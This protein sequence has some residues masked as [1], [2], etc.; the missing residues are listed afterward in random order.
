VWSGGYTYTITLN[1]NLA[2]SANPGI[3]DMAGNAL[4]PNQSSGIVQYTITLVSGV[5]FSHAPGYPVAWHMLT[6]NPGL[7]LGTKAPLPQADYVPCLVRSPNTDDGVNFSGVSL[8][9]GESVTLPVTITVPAGLSAVYLYGWIDYSDAGTFTSSDE[10]F[11]NAT[12]GQPLANLQVGVNHLNL[13]IQ[14]PATAD[15]GTTWARFRV[16]TAAGLSFD[17]GAPDGEVE[18]YAVNILP[19]PAEIDGTVW[20][21]QNDN[22]AHDTGEPGLGGWTVTATD[23][24]GK[25][26]ATAITSS[27]AGALGTYS[28][29]GLAPGT[30][31]IREQAPAAG[32]QETAPSTGYLL[33][34]VASGQ[35]SP[36]NDFENF[37]P[38]NAEIDGLVWDDLTGSGGAYTNQPVL[39]GW[40]VYVDLNNSDAW[41]ANDPTAISQ[42]DGTFD[43][44]IPAAEQTSNNQY[45]VREVPQ[46]NWAETA[47]ASGFWNV[48]VAAGQDAAISA[49]FGDHYLL[50][51]MVN[52]LTLDASAQTPTNAKAV[53]FD[54]TFSEPVTGLVA[55]DFQVVPSIPGPSGAVVSTIGA[56]GSVQTYNGKS[57][58]S[59]WIVTINTGS[60]DGTLTFNLQDHGTIF[61]MSGNLLVAAD[62]TPNV[63]AGPTITIDKTP[64]T[65]A[66]TLDA[67]SHNPTNAASVTFDVTFSQAVTGVAANNGTTFTNLS[68]ASPGL[69]GAAI[70]KVSFSGAAQVVNGV[71]YYTTW[72][73]TV[74]SGLGNSGTLQ[75]SVNPPVTIA[76]PAGNDLI[77]GTSGPVVTIDRVQP[78][79]AISVASG[80]ANPA[81]AGPIL[82]TVT[83]SK[84]VTGFAAAGVSLAKSTAAGTLK[85]TVTP[86][87]SSGSAGYYTT[88]QVSVSGMT[89]GGTVVAGVLAGAATDAAGNASVVSTFATVTYNP[90]TAVTLALA[91]RNPTNGKSLTT[92]LAEPITFTA[93]FSQAVSNF[94][95]TA[96][97]AAS[98]LNFTGSTAGTGGTATGLTGTVTYSGFSGGTYNYSVVVSG[99][100]GTGNIVLAINKG[101]VLTASGGGNTASNSASVFYDITPPVAVMESPANG[102]SIGATTLNNQRYIEIAYSA[103]VGAGLSTA[104]ILNAKTAP[105]TLTGAAATGV[106]ITMPPTKASGTDTYLYAFTGSF[107]AGTV[108]VNLLANTV[109]DNAGNWNK[110]ASFSFTTMPGL[111]V[112]NLG[113]TKATSGTTTAVFTVSLSS[114]ATKAVSVR[115]ATANGTGATAGIA[116]TNYTAVSGTLSFAVG[117][118]SKTVSVPIIGNTVNKVAT[119]SLVL[120]A[121]TNAVITTSTGTGTINPPASVTKVTTTTTTTTTKVTSTSATTAVKAASAAPVTTTVVTPTTTTTT[122]SAAKAASLVVVATPSATATT[123]TTSASK[124]AAVTAT[125][126]MALVLDIATASQPTAK[127]TTTQKTAA[128]DAAIAQLVRVK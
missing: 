33:V 18:D 102:A 25:V 109:E 126:S 122:A 62:E 112:N 49:N 66:I 81:S 20:N 72:T 43:L 65:A 13:T 80:Q 16:S 121:P 124:G 40:K 123:S 41:S 99:M 77:A 97:L 61:D 1:N 119:F 4:Q 98:Q 50:H 36:G 87:T 86:V 59:T 23:S 63:F 108:T 37:L 70:T 17:G 101:T 84:P 68:L 105:F 83:F 118:T 46:V 58:S 76:D 2:T 60:G 31:W 85:A 95:T 28:L 93:T 53:E 115:Y 19:K 64:P 71:S 106:K 90:L 89:G 35:D 104:S 3:L 111:S 120:S 14:V 52:S 128:V 113:V 39:S 100:A 32:W 116:G 12:A 75:L 107:T 48:T 55:G 56:S 73:V 103:N 47:P 26:D 82:F 88:Y 92:G 5:N 125:M 78:T 127:I 27:V 117:Q 91:S 74:S 10:V 6:N 44:Q 11:A 21:D 110:A 45:I 42:S 30:Y 79:T 114:P 15:I 69:S 24:N 67:S 9:Q 54:V 38:P 22:G 8:T 7:Y 57:Y 51:P 34:T 94:G 96:A 29:S